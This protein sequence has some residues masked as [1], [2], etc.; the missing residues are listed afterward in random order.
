[1]SRL[2][3]RVNDVYNISNYLIENYNNKY[4]KDKSKIS[5]DEL[6]NSINY[7]IP[8][9]SK[10]NINYINKCDVK[11][12]YNKFIKDTL[13]SGVGEEENVIFF[14][15][16]DMKE[17]Y[18]IDLLYFIGDLLRRKSLDYMPDEY[19]IKC[20]YSDTLPLLIEYLYLKEV[21]KE[22]RFSLRNL[23]DLQLNAFDYKKLYERFQK[24]PY[25]YSEDNMLR[26]TL[27]FLVPLSSMDATLQII[28]K[29]YNNKDEL[30]KLINE[31]VENPN[32]NREEAMQKRDIETYGFKRLRKEIDLRRR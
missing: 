27:L 28:D 9:L 22:D 17:E 16:K 21:N 1:M 32:H 29:Y 13:Y 25:I 12:Y 20:Q 4:V 11:I 2:Y 15:T 23:S 5:N 8:Y 19:D 7:V 30:I 14:K 18:K 26:N 31:L 3:G 24:Y 6:E 10:D